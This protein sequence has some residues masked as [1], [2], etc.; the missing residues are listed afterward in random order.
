MLARFGLK[1]PF[2][3]DL[4]RV[5]LDQQGKVLQQRLL[6]MRHLGHLQS[7]NG[8]KSHHQQK[9]S[10]ACSQ[11]SFLLL[12][13]HDHQLSMA[14]KCCTSPCVFRWKFNL[15]KG[16]WVENV[17]PFIRWKWPSGTPCNWFQSRIFKSQITLGLDVNGVTTKC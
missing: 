7:S 10:S 11:H 1:I 6:R 9:S 15:C 12:Y 17:I 2:S 4:L 3:F 8:M 14:T 5:L 13:L 16:E